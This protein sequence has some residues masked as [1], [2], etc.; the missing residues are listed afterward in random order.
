MLN[1][2]YA[3]WGLLLVGSTVAALQFGSCITQWLV[4]TAILNWVD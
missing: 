1:K 2:A 3:K 4:D